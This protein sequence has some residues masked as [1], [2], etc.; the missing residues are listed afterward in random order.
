MLREPP[1]T[2]VFRPINKDDDS[3]APLAVHRP[4]V[5]KMLQEA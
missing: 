3:L 4:D 2:T 1:T 5:R